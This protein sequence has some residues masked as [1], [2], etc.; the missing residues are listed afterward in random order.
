MKKFSRQSFRDPVPTQSY[1]I[2]W[3][4]RRRF[5]LQHADTLIDSCELKWVLY[6][7]R[8]EERTSLAGVQLTYVEQD[9]KR[10]KALSWSSHADFGY[11]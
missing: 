7:S 11:H 2:Q 4:A 3:H 9:G 5:R 8:I 1:T 6:S 10:S